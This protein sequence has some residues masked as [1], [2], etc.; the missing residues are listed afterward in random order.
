[1]LLVIN[2]FSL[3]S[4]AGVLR[5]DGRHLASPLEGVMPITHEL[6][7]VNNDR[8]HHCRPGEEDLS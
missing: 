5:L 6:S 7:M 2:T 8:R 4:A 1:M 3:G